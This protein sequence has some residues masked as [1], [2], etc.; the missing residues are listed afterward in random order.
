M[1]RIYIFILCTLLCIS[2]A[3]TANS[4]KSSS[5]DF[6]SSKQLQQLTIEYGN[7]VNDMIN[8]LKNNLIAINNRIITSQNLSL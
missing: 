2:V 6:L 7:A 1:N 3:A 8:M 4:S 5:A